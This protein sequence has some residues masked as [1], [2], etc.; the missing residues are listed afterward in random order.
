MNG[1]GLG[2]AGNDVNVGIA[3]SAGVAGKA[4]EAARDCSGIGVTVGRER[5]WANALRRG[6]INGLAVAPAVTSTRLRA[7]WATQPKRSRIGGAEE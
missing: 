3:V 2:G 7:A 4:G 1:R 5:S 6:R